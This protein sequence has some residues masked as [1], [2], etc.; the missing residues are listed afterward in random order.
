[1]NNYVSRI[2]W[3]QD[4]GR[5]VGS[6]TSRWTEGNPVGTRRPCLF[7]LSTLRLYAA[8]L[9]HCLMPSAQDRAAGLR[10]EKQK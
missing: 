4:G 7:S 6:C 5:M 1:M 3:W 9:S 10:N 2:G 8:L